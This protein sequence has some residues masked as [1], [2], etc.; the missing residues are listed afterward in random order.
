MPKLI[1]PIKNRCGLSDL[2]SSTNLPSA[3]ITTRWSV[4]FF[5]ELIFEKSKMVE[6]ST[7]REVSLTATQSSALAT[8][9]KTIKIKNTFV[10]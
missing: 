2:F 8:D 7:I 3:L 6:G 1:E 9:K 4:N 10:L 5:S